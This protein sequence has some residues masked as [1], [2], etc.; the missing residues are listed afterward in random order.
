MPE[1][2]LILRFDLAGA[3][4]PIQQAFVQSGNGRDRKRTD[5]RKKQNGTDPGFSEWRIRAPVD[6]T[7]RRIVGRK[8][9]CADVMVG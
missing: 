4:P 2:T 6:R 8:L 1:H 7:G 3:M 5:F 9:P